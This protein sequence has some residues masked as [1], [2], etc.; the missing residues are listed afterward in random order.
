MFITKDSTSVIDPYSSTIISK[1]TRSENLDDIQ[2]FGFITARP[3]FSLS[4]SH[5]DSFLLLFT[6][7]GRGQ[8]LY[9]G[10]TYDLD[11]T[12]VLFIDCHEPYQLKNLDHFEFYFIHTNGSRIPYYF[13]RFFVNWHDS[14]DRR[15]VYDSDLGSYFA[16]IVRQLIYFDENNFND[17]VIMTS[18]LDYL[19]SAIIVDKF[20]TL[21]SNLS[22]SDKTLFLLKVYLD[23]HY[24]E[25]I[26]LPRLAQTFNLSAS[27][28]S[29]QFKAYYNVSPK[30]YLNKVRVDHAKTLLRQT[31]LSLIEICQEIGVD[32]VAYFIRFFKRYTGMTPKTYKINFSTPSPS[33]L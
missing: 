1:T 9:K 22:G 21:S 13:E 6:T 14:A 20:K 23:T 30:T 4:S 33:S 8:L 27:S 19:L 10:V 29:K 7:N 24:A 32:D 16:S 26:T 5:L 12:K 3:Q 17:D 25:K 28:I 15:A 18:L 11:Q 2:E 31:Q